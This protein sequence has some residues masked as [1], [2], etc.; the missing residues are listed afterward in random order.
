MDVM[1]AFR[2]LRG[3]EPEIAPLLARRGLDAA[4]G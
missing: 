2:E 4:A 3:R 1:D